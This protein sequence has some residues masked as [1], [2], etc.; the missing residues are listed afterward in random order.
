[1]LYTVTNVCGGWC[2]FFSSFQ[3][4]YPLSSAFERLILP[5][6]SGPTA[7]IERQWA[8]KLLSCTR[9]RGGCVEFAVLPC[10]K[11]GFTT[12]FFLDELVGTLCGTGSHFWYVLRVVT[13]GFESIIV[14]LAFRALYHY[15]GLY[16]NHTGPETLVWTLLRDSIAY[17]LVW[18]SFWILFWKI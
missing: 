13:L 11:C 1:M 14:A 10:S 2:G 6:V 3:R 5:C 7:F 9:V 17:Y 4:W 12:T 18:V 16:K 15:R 8:G